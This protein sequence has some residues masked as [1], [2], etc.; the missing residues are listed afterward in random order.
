MSAALGGHRYAMAAV[1]AIG[2]AL[3][4]LSLAG[5]LYIVAGLARRLTTAGLRWSAGRPARRLLVAVAGAACLTALA[6]FWA[7]QGQFRGW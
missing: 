4:A 3:L 1:D 2:F 5:S 7:A 6:G